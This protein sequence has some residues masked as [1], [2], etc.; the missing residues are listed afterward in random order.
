MGDRQVREVKAIVANA[1]WELHFDRQM[2]STMQTDLASP[3]R[4]ELPLDADH[5]SEQLCVTG[6]PHVS[7]VG[8]MAV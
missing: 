3:D 4:L 7:G 8:E 1:V 6:Y 5:F 2:I